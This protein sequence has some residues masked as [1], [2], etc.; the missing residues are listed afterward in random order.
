ME[1]LLLSQELLLKAS[2][3]LMQVPLQV[4]LLMFY[5]VGMLVM[6]WPLMLVTGNLPG[7]FAKM[8]E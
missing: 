4:V 8:N 1:H 3:A 5:C 2:A 7:V 6:L